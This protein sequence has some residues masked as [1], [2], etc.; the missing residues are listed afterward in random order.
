MAAKAQSP[1]FPFDKFITGY[2]KAREGQEYDT[3]VAARESKAPAAAPRRR[4]G[5]MGEEM[6]KFEVKLNN[7]QKCYTTTET[8][9]QSVL[10]E[11]NTALEIVSRYLDKKYQQSD[12]RARKLYLSN[13][14]LIESP[15]AKPTQLQTAIIA[16]G[17]FLLKVGVPT[18]VKTRDLCDHS[19]N[20]VDGLLD[21]LEDD[22]V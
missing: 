10:E 1:G 18:R 20:F 8:D 15:T 3:K 7:S 21:A 5:R 13:Q 4:S 6:T 17:D 2:L 9:L 16:T 22:L 19:K 11:L 12:V 14:R